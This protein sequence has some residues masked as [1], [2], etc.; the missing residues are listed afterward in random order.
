MRPSFLLALALLASPA[1]AQLPFVETFDN[2]SNVG[3]WSLGQ[4]PTFPSTGGNPGWYMETL[5]DTFAPQVRSTDPSSPFGGD[6]R[7]KGVASV[8]IDARTLSVQFPF[9]R[10]MTLALG[11]D[12]GTPGNLIDDCIVYFVGPKRVPQV[13]QG[14]RS[15]DFY[16]DVQ[17]PT[18]PA[19][20]K[21]SASASGCTDPDAAWNKIIQDVSYVEFF[22]GDPEFFYIF[23][24]WRVGVDNVRISA[25][26]PASTYCIP[27]AN[28]QGCAPGMTLS[29]TPSATSGSPF[30][31]GAQEVIN[32]KN[33]LLIYGFAPYN[34]PFQGGTLCVTGLV[35]RTTAQ[36]SGGNGGADDCS[37]SYSYDFNA[38][39]QSGVDPLLT[40]GEQVFAQ[41]WYRDP[42]S[43][44]GTG[45]TDAAQFTIQP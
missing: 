35:R 43:S 20:W 8:G 40:V 42:A 30:L 22:F 44:A 11:W 1:A 17:S 19:G 9:D 28:S 32:N 38:R 4:P 3:A 36:W 6:W 37:G 34:V 16:V 13:A 24:Q 15:Y 7:A 2:G 10:E 21:L 41:Y 12:N 5:V 25:E 45:L 18:L 14:W 31:L 26:L 23:D 29:G 33:G 27:K 39:I